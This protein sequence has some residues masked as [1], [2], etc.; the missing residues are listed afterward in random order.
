MFR[1][2]SRQ[3]RRYV[4]CFSNWI[5]FGEFFA[6][7]STVTFY[8][9]IETKTRCFCCVS[10]YFHISSV[11]RFFGQIFTGWIFGNISST[12][13]RTFSA[14]NHT[15]TYLFDRLWM[16]TDSM[17]YLW[18]IWMGKKYYLITDITRFLFNSLR[19]RVEASRNF[20]SCA[21]KSF[22]AFYFWFIVE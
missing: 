12:P 1:Y 10:I 13:E 8:Q 17:D 16:K 2:V 6:R 11:R 20:S 7:L 18:P 5:L 22:T 4:N 14:I 19:S 9:Q 15:K 3:L 21:R